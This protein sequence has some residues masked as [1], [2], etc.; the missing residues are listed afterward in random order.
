ME[1]VWR[2]RLRYSAMIHYTRS[3]AGAGAGARVEETCDRRYHSGRGAVRYS[4]RGCSARRWLW[5]LNERAPLQ[6][7]DALDRRAGSFLSDG[8]F[9]LVLGARSRVLRAGGGVA[10]M[11]YPASRACRF[12]MPSAWNL[13]RAITRACWFAL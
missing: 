10:A 8:R 12:S 13:H 6:M 11:K 9:P 2:S 7:A 3:S 4:R 5:P 1:V